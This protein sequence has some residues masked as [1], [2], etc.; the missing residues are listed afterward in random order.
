[1]KNLMVEIGIIVQ[2][3]IKRKNKE[4]MKSL[5]DE[6]DYIA[7]ENGCMDM[8]TVSMSREQFNELK[9]KYLGDW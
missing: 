2:K 3:Y 1:M 4:N 8:N 5:L 7:R 6:I 9:E